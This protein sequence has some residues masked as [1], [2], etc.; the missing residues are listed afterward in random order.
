[1]KTGLANAVK[2]RAAFVGLDAVSEEG[3]LRFVFA[4]VFAFKA[5][6]MREDAVDEAFE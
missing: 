6:A 5:L 4:A 3:G 1:L 2:M